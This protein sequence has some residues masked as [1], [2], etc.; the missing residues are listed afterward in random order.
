MR[1]EFE[2]LYREDVNDDLDLPGGQQNLAGQTTAVTT[3]FN[4]Y[5]DFDLSN[6]AAENTAAARL[7]PFVGGGFGFAI[8]DFEGAAAG[9]GTIDGFDQV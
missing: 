8:V 2:S 6:P 1:F 7:K 5:Y 4:V 3:M 9:V